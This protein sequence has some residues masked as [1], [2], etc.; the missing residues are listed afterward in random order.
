PPESALHVRPAFGGEATYP[1]D[2]PLLGL[3][4]YLLERCD[5]ARAIGEGHD[6]YPV[7]WIE[8]PDKA[9]DRLDHVLQRRTGH[10]TG[11]VNAEHYRERRTH[12]LHAGGR[13]ADLRDEVSAGG[14][15]GLD[16]LD[17]KGER[18]GERGRVHPLRLP[19]E[20]TEL[21]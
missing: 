18:E 3:A 21:T 1:A 7:F 4:V 8:Q 5:V 9:L 13:G 17:I 11:D 20:A 2:D 14:S 12:A 16:A 19:P 6:A 10:R 15:V